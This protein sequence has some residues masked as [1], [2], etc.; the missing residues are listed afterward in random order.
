MSIKSSQSFIFSFLSFS[1][2]LA[3]AYQLD[4]A[5]A[6]LNTTWWLAHVRFYAKFPTNC[7]QLKE[8]FMV[9]NSQNICLTMLL[10]WCDL[11]C[12]EWH[13]AIVCKWQNHRSFS[14]SNC[15]LWTERG[16]T[17]MRKLVCLKITLHSYRQQHGN[18]FSNF[19]RIKP[20]NECVTKRRERK[21]SVETRWSWTASV[22]M[23]GMKM[24]ILRLNA[25][26]SELANKELK[27]QSFYGTI[28][29]KWMGARARSFSN[30]FE[31]EI[32]FT[33]QRVISMLDFCCCFNLF[34][35]EM[36]S[37]ERENEREREKHEHKHTEKEIKLFDSFGECAVCVPFGLFC[38]HRTFVQ[39][40]RRSHRKNKCDEGK[41][42]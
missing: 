11:P 7:R 19:E 32:A 15:V 28:H 39:H 21:N 14:I 30:R 20:I 9:D 35:F 26:H 4:D 40:L 18:V 34:T 38:L 23:K 41:K 6:H 24:A 27:W 33:F 8:F 42:N 13:R 37:T 3:R 31:F 16:I 12:T 1:L 36:K 29:H 2:S 25:N 17:L 10:Y 5:W 22:Q